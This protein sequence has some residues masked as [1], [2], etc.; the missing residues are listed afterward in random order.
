MGKVIKNPIEVKL[1]FKADGGWHLIPSVHYGVGAEEYPDLS[2]RK[3]MPLVFTP[4][5]E[6]AI[7]QMAADIVYPQIL[8][9][10]GIISD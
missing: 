3:G 5:Q 8:T 10:E 1:V 2:I 9:N 7:I 4:A 6:T